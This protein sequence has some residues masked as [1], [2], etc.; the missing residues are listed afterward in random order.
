LWWDLD[1]LRLALRETNKKHVWLSDFDK[2]A[3]TLLPPQPRFLHRRAEA[4]A[5]D[6]QADLCSSQGL[7]AFFFTIN[8]GRRVRSEKSDQCL[9]FLSRTCRRACEVLP[10]DSEWP[11]LAPLKITRRNRVSGF[12]ELLS[13]QH[14]NIGR[15]W[16]D[17][18]NSLKNE[19]VL[20]QAIDDQPASTLPLEDIFR[21][22]ALWPQSTIA[23]SIIIAPQ[24][25]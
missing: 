16:I 19:S 6:I 21:F 20:S 3:R 18:W 4:G 2:K 22:L 25:V 9:E 8:V 12:V 1:Y 10:A 23:S 24:S 14:V 15:A 11:V 17:R 5:E 7:L 13:E